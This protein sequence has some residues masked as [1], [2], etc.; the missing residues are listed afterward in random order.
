MTEKKKIK[1]KK[2]KRTPEEIE[3]IRIARAQKKAE[4]EKALRKKAEHDVAKE[5]DNIIHV[6]ISQ[7]ET[8]RWQVR[9][10]IDSIFKKLHDSRHQYVLDRDLQKAE[11]LEEDRNKI[12]N[13]LQ[14]WGEEY[15]ENINKV[16]CECLKYPDEKLNKEAYKF[17]AKLLE[18]D[19]MGLSFWMYLWKQGFVPN[20]VLELMDEE[21]IS[22]KHGK[23][24]YAKTFRKMY[25]H[26]VLPDDMKRHLKWE[27]E[28]LEDAKKL[29]EPAKRERQIVRVE[30][31]IKKF[32]HLIEDIYKR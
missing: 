25:A 15:E 7:K 5:Q 29:E 32:E 4:A 28:R 23:T 6:S 13:I 18:D 19:R 26:I 14:H 11:I 27:R 10:Y 12:I 30:A 1:E 8:Q 2:Q 31:R 22:P 24:G 20:D 3:E 16:L 9:E 17:I 21:H